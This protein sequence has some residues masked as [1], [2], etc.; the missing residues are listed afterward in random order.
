MLCTVARN[1][2]E[3]HVQIH[4]LTGLE[5]GAHVG[6][7]LEHRELHV[8]EGH[9]EMLLFEDLTSTFKELGNGTVYIDDDWNVYVV[10]RGLVGRILSRFF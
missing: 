2:Q 9:A 8:I 3:E 5:F 6:L 1:A 7:P 10:R 4:E